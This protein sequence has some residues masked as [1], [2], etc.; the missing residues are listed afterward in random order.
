MPQQIPFLLSLLV[1]VSPLHAA[2]DFAHEVVPILEKN[3]VECHGGDKSKGGLSMNTRELLLEAD[4]LEPGKPEDSLFIEVLTAVDPDERMPP[5]DKKK[6]ALKPA[7]IAMLERWIAEGA[8][9][10]EGFTFAPERY[11]PPLKPRTV[12]LPKG[13][14]GTNP[15]DLIVAAHLKKNGTEPPK[16]VDDRT[17]LR[18]VTLDITGLPPTPEALSQ[19]PSKGKLDRAAAVNKLLANNQAYAEHWMTFWND[20]LRNEYIGTGYIEGGRAQVTGWLYRSLLENKPF[21]AFIRDLVAPAAESTG[22]VKGIVWR[23]QVNASQTTEIQFSQNVSQVFLGINMKC[24]SCHDSFVDR[25]TLREAYGL[26]AIYSEKPLELTRCDKPTGEM[27]VASW[28]FPEL[29]NVDPAKPRD[30]R[31]KQ[32]AELITHPENGRTQRT[33]VN[34]LWNQMMG[35]G[36]VHPVDAMNTEPWNEDLLDHL[37]NHLVASKYDLKAVMH[38]IATSRT[39]Q[40]RTEISGEEDGKYVFQ[41]PLRKRMTAEQFMDS[42]RSVIAVWPAPEKS[43][44]GKGLTGGQLTAVI[45]AHGLKDWD[46]R[47]VRSVFAKRDELQAALGRPNR[48]QIVSSRPDILTTLEAIN[49][50]NGPELAALLKAGA[51]NLQGKAAPRELIENTYLAALS[52]KPTE[53]EVLIATEILGETPTP[54]ATEDFLWSVFMLPEFIYIN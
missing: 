20:L 22:F 47:P 49:L 28:I 6:M 46:N 10:E 17:F 16:Q 2:V 52:R 32:L 31:L 11:E 13:A 4:V 29:G 1:M 42:I 43:A 37:A 48:E 30:E 14:P 18:R 5:P 24:A 45:E 33:I 26:A 25:W 54:E 39:Y 50:A 53:S 23:G 21:D 27:A 8:E 12:K 41:G 51:A 36:I 3:C 34:R 44:F 15:I 38:L 19:L 35:R 9:W 40:S 7:E